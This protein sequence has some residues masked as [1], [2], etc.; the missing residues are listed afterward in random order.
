MQILVAIPIISYERDIKDVKFV[1]LDFEDANLGEDLK[2]YID[3]M[4][5]EPEYRFVMDYALGL[6]RIPTILSIYMAQNFVSS[7]RKERK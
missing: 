6:K 1:D 4:V 5:T 2:C 3:K 7:V